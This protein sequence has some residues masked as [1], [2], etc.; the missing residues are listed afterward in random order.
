M[1]ALR[2][3]G[4]QS[5]EVFIFDNYFDDSLE[6]RRTESNKQIPAATETLRLP[7]S[8]AIGMRTSRSHFSRVSR[9]IP[10]PSAP[11]THAM[12]SGRLAW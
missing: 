10:S 5:Q 1:C 3:I 12:A 4:S 8:P 9:R 7:T 6:R 2:A 11:S